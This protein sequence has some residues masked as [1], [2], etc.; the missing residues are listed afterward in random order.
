MRKYLADRLVVAG[1]VILAVGS[2][3]LL[4][5]GLLAK[6]GFLSD[7]NP[8]PIGFGLLFFFSFWPGVILTV[9]G[10]LRVRARQSGGAKNRSAS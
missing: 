2:G 10:F 9:A 7:P 1:I 6:F 4:A 5:V 8:N 3:P